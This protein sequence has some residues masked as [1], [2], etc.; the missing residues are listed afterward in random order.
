MLFAVNQ[1]VDVG[2]CE[3]DVVTV[4]DCISR[5]SLDA[6]AAKNASRII[7][8][9][10]LGIAIAC[11]NAIRVSV[12]RRFNVNTICWAGGG[13]EEAT[14]AFFKAIFIALQHVDSAITWLNTRRDVWIRLRRRLTEHRA[15]S[16]AEPL[17]QG[18]KCFTDFL[19][20]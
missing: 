15:Q 2:R 8:V 20:D 9:I 4:R 11:R 6:I 5:T 16:H 7:N 10:D 12:F 17:I 19:H 1:G 18:Y 14:H 13:A 3:F